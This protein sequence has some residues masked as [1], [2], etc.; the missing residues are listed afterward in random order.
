VPDGIKR[1][2]L[3]QI[4]KALDHLKAHAQ[5]SDEAIHDARRRFKLMRAF[6]QP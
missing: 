2:A 1:I 4:E 5:E 3:E 6:P